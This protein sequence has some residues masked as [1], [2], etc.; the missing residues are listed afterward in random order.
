M[1]MRS[2]LDCVDD[3]PMDNQY[4]RA[5]QIEGCQIRKEDE[6]AGRAA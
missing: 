3:R 1:G 4:H 5:S 6:K 2:T